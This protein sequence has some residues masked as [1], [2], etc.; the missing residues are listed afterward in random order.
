M[1]QGKAGFSMDVPSFLVG[2]DNNLVAGL[3]VVGLKRAGY[4]PAQRA[5]L[6]RAFDLIY[7][8][9]K[10]MSQ[11]LAAAQAEQWSGPAA[12]FLTFIAAAG[13]KGVCALRHQ[14]ASLE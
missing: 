5:A 10:N 7:R 9:G 3:N 13:K 14:A 8:S 12:E 6:K 11:A 2:V 4:A 1:I